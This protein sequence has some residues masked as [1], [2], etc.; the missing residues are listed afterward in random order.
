MQDYEKKP[1]NNANAK[2]CFDVDVNIL[3]SLTFNKHKVKLQA[4][5]SDKILFEKIRTAAKKYIHFCEKVNIDCLKEINCLKCILS[6]SRYATS[7][8]KTIELCNGLERVA[9]VGVPQTSWTSQTSSSLWTIVDN[10]SKP[11]LLSVC[12]PHGIFYQSV[13]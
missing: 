9:N 8:E 5:S 10:S 7:V 13:V 1:E 4:L 6:L 3:S 2:D 11:S 12:P